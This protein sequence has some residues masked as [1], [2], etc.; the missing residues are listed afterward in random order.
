ML[1]LNTGDVSYTAAATSAN[2]DRQYLLPDGYSQKPR[3]PEESFILGIAS[4][5]HPPENG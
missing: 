3:V 4:V 5:F 1:D 2:E